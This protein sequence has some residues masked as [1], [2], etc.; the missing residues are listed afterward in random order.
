MGLVTRA[1]VY[2]Y[3]LHSSQQTDILSLIIPPRRLG[4][5]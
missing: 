5:M 3:T 2:S 1:E 4:T